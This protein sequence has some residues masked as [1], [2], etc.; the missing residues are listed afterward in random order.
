MK[1]NLDGAAHWKW[2]L[3]LECDCILGYDAR[4]GRDLHASTLR[5]RK[6]KIPSDCVAVLVQDQSS[7]IS[8]SWIVCHVQPKVL[9][10]HR[11]DTLGRARIA[12]LVRCIFVSFGS[13]WHRRQTVATCQIVDVRPQNTPVALRLGAVVTADHDLVDA[14]GIVEHA[15]DLGPRLHPLIRGIELT[16]Q[17]VSG[18]VQIRERVFEIVFGVTCLRF[19]RIR[20]S[21]TAGAAAV[22]RGLRLCLALLAPI[23]RPLAEFI[24]TVLDLADAVAYLDF[25][26][27]CLRQSEA[28][29]AYPNEYLSS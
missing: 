5:V 20:S 16:T 24:H 6:H 17:P 18:T 13:R 23:L 3:A 10:E 25:S 2:I 4:G 19:L 29:T 21:T 15:L 27:S 28:S 22:L 11:D 1:R 12:N 8:L 7:A 9:V 26:K 14:A